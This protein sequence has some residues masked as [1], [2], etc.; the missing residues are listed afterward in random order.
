VGG[1]PIEDFPGTWIVVGIAKSD[2]IYRLRVLG[3]FP[4]PAVEPGETVE[5]PDY[6]AL[7]K[8]SVET[9]LNVL[10]PVGAVVTISAIVLVV[11]SRKKPK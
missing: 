4:A 7:G 10:L 6:L 3:P 2:G 5:P 8:M 1:L 9:P 11:W